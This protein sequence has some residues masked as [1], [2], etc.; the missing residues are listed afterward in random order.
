MLIIDKTKISI[1]KSS[2]MIF[3]NEKYIYDAYFFNIYRGK[4]LESKLCA[5]NKYNTPAQYHKVTIIGTSRTVF[6]NGK[7]IKEINTYKK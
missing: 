5:E 3:S 2:G 4:I 1:S 7:L 6:F